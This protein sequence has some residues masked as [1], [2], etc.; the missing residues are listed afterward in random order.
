M[1]KLIFAM[2]LIFAIT[3]LNA[4][5]INSYGFKGGLCIANQDFDYVDAV[6]EFDMKTRYGLDTGFFIELL[7]NE[8]FNL[9]VET[10]YVQKGHIFELTVIHE[11]FFGPDA[12]SNEEFQ[13]RVDYLTFDVLCKFSVNHENV[14]SYLFAGPRFDILLDY[15]SEEHL[16]DVIYDKLEPIDYGLDIGFGFEFQ[17]IQK[18]TS[19]IELRYSPTIT[20]SYEGEYYTIKNT[21][22]EILTGIKF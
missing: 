18:T 16:F 7:N 11:E 8:G 17:I 15:D 2:C 3:L 12:Y 6:H 1:K 10:H 5:L 9:L 22:F 14:T 20:T 19:L 4:Q 13:S 21:S